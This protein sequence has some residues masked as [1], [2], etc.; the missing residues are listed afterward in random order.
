VVAVQAL[1]AA[2]AGS[3]L[4]VVLTFGVAQLIMTLRPQFLIIIEPSAVVQSLVA[5]L[6]MALLSA[7]FPARMVARL[8]PAEVFRK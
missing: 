6:A 2:S 5:G 3:A 7:L 1:I 4:G 8:A